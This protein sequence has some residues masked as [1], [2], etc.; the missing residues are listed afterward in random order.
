MPKKL[1]VT[2]K[3]RLRAKYGNSGWR[4]IRDA[5][6]KLIAAD[7]ERQV[8]T[9]VVPIDLKGEMRPLGV[10]AVS[11]ADDPEQIKS[12]LDALFAA[13]EP[14]YVTI[15]GSPD[16]VPHQPL[17]NPV[18]DEDFEVLSDLPYACDAG[19]SEEISEFSGPSRVVGRLPDQEGSD[20]V[21]PLL[22]ALET[23]TSWRRRSRRAYASYF[24]LSTEAWRASTRL[25]IRKLFRSSQGVHLAPPEGPAWSKEALEPRV[26]FY[27]LHGATFDPTFY[28]DDDVSDDHEALNSPQILGRI[29]EGTVIAAECCFGAELYDHTAFAPL[30]LDRGICSAALAS[31]A[32]G[33]MGSTNVAYGPK[34]GNDYADLICLFFVR[35]VLAGASLGRALLEARQRYVETKA[36][37]DPVD[38]KTLAQFNLLG[39]PSVHPVRM[40]APA[41]NAL[42]KSR[43][44][45][46][47]GKRR[48]TLRLKGLRLARI[49]AGV[50]S[51][52]DSKMAGKLRGELEA[53][54]SK[55]GYQAY[56]KSASFRIHK[57]AQ[58]ALAKTPA[59]KR[60]ATASGRVHLMFGR[61]PGRKPR[62]EGPRREGAAQRGGDMLMIAREEGGRIRGYQAVYRR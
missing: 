28:G 27:N 26:H 55:I 8:V 25:S 47:V 35:N 9:S 17:L 49:L 2:N 23:A 36:P 5:L 57:P 59:A 13:I 21:E 48:R 10:E 24:A 38:L 46:S 40:A 22:G 41:A 14:D 20:D 11:E 37:L 58:P 6:D 42:A 39:D 54:L 1:I 60:R 15:L 56:G 53:R 33:F 32:C 19:F 45:G 30:E 29:R 31:G 18:T 3:R 52:A 7:H 51:H 43:T 12:A 34:S 4:R 44:R 62:P 50:R 16:V 61:S